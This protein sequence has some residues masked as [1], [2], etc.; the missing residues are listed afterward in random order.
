MGAI[1]SGYESFANNLRWAW[2]H[3]QRRADREE[4]DE[5][6]FVMVPWYQRS[7]R[8]APKGNMKM[9]AREAGDVEELPVRPGT[10]SQWKRKV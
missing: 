9:E 10:P 8:R 3:H 1:I 7:I 5:D 6:D 2:F 4:E